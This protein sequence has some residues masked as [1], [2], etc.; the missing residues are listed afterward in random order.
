MDNNAT[1][2][3]LCGASAN[4]KHD[5]YPGYQAPDTFRIYHCPACN[6]GFSLPRVDPG[7]LYETIYKNGDKVPGYNRY[8]R[9]AKTIRIFKNPL[10]YLSGSS[11]VY[12]GVYKALS[13]SVVDKRSSKILE[14]GSGLGYLTYSLIMADYNVV[15]MDISQ[16]AVNKANETFGD[17]YISADLFEYAA[18]HPESFDIVI[19]T[20][21]IEH[22]EDP[23]AFIGSI[24]KLLKPGGRAIITTPNKSFYPPVVTWAS[25]LP[26]VHCWWLGEES[27]KYIADKLGI[28]LSLINFSEFFKKNYHVVRIGSGR[29]LPRPFISGDGELIKEASRSKSLSKAYLE[30]ILT[31]IPL[32]GGLTGIVKKVSGK[33]KGFLNPDILVCKERGIT[34]CAILQKPLK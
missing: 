22:V 19:L 8:W 7:S 10:K 1:E 20:E 31:K 28:S 34:L 2:C 25:D 12:W 26:P 4:L 27:I 14:V 21:V 32:A 17:H 6:T 16:T 23:V 24:I 30:L 5:K 18:L 33:L 9:Y 11:E 29:N 3:L 15:G 13:E